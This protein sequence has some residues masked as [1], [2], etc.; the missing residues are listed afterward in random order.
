V[1]TIKAVPIL[2]EVADTRD[3]SDTNLCCKILALLFE[4]Q[5]APIGMVGTIEETKL[6]LKRIEEAKFAPAIFVVNTFGAKPIL[7]DLDALIAETPVLYLRR[8]LYA[9]RS[10]LMDQLGGDVCV[11]QTSV[12]LRKMRPRRTAMWFYGSKNPD[13]IAKRAVNSLIRF[14]EN[15]DFLDIE[16]GAPHP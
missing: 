4:K 9:G 8:A 2:V 12:V 14:L 6:V 15:G 5:I 10:G 7:P 1:P 11:Q 16:A 13:E 3:K